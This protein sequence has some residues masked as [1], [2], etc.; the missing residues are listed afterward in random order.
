MRMDVTRLGTAFGWFRGGEKE[1][2]RS[3]SWQSAYKGKQ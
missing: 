2:E 1:L 3:L